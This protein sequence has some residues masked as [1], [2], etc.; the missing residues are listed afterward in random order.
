MRWENDPIGTGV[1]GEKPLPRRTCRGRI[2]AEPGA[3]VRIAKLQRM[4]YEV[5]AQDCFAPSAPI[6][7][8]NWPGVWPCA[9][10]IRTLVE[11]S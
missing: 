2:D 4:M 5:S 1:P 8:M 3:P 10:S 7:T 11:T 9:G 6:L